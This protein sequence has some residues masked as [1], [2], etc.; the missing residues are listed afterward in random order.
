MRRP[1]TR[2][3]TSG[4]VSALT[5]GALLSAPA[6]AADG[7]IADTIDNPGV[8]EK[9]F[10]AYLYDNG[11]GYLNSA[12]VDT[13]GKLVCA[14]RAAGVPDSRIIDLLERRGFA[15][16]EARAIVTATVYDDD[17]GQPLCTD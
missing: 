2:T 12:R 8:A 17:G 13:D 3:I 7:T 15:P 5:V 6:A 10:W 1:A 16:N 11:F 9:P 4:I 14:N